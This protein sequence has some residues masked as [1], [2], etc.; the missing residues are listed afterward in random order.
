[1]IRWIARGLI[2]LPLLAAFGCG[3]TLQEGKREGSPDFP[4]A[5][6]S[7]DQGNYLDAIPDFKAYIEQFPGTDRTDDAL[8]YLGRCYIQ[9]KDYALASAQFDRLLRDFPTSSLQADALLELARCDDLQSHP[10]PLDQAETQQALTRYNQ[11]V[12]QYPDHPRIGEAKARV[13]VLRDRLAEKLLRSGRLYDKLRRVRASEFYLRKVL[14]DYPESKWVPEATR[15]LSEV[16]AK[17]GRK[18]EAEEVRKGAS[19]TSGQEPKPKPDERPRGLQ[20]SEAPG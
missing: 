3:G 1:M 20:A 18:A 4:K 17:Q 19:P 12:E 5:K 11:F 9:E 16:L 6:T 14:A 10:A 2:L 15:L 7:F 13:R 8:Y